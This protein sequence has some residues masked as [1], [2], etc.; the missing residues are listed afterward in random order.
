MRACAPCY[1]R[2]PPS[3]TRLGAS[4]TPAVE[5]DRSGPV[6]AGRP[7]SPPR[8]AAPFQLPATGSSTPTVAVAGIVLL[9]LG[10]LALTATRSDLTR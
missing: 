1:E 9:A 10:L 5:S 7:Q 4:A 3:P 6:A 8:P 2:R